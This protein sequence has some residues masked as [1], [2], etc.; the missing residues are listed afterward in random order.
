MH[1]RNRVRHTGCNRDLRAVVRPHGDP[2]GHGIAHVTDLAA[3]GVDYRL[4]ALRPPPARLEEEASKREALQPHNFDAR[5]ARGP[6][7][8]RLLVGFRFK[9]RHDHSS[10]HVSSSLPSAYRRK[11]WSRSVTVTSWNVIWSSQSALPWCGAGTAWRASSSGG[12]LWVFALSSSPR[13]FTSLQQR[14]PA[15][16]AADCFSN[17]ATTCDRRS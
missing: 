2:A 9:L 7:F 13:T 15:F 1:R 5:L 16:M 12:S 4:D 6:D 11:P 14:S 8:V 17:R 10:R 3:V